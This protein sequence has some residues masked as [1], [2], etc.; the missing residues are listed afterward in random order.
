MWNSSKC[1]GMFLGPS[2]GGALVDNYGYQVTASVFIAMNCLAFVADVKELWAL[3]QC[4]NQ[5][6]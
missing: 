3:H 6:S 5:G 4:K 2:T 1:L